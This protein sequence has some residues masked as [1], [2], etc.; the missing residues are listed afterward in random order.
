MNMLSSVAVFTLGLCVS[1]FLTP[2]IVGKL[3]A[4]AY[5][6]LGLS[7]NIISYTSLL[8]VI[9]NSMAGRFI[10]IQV[11][12]GDYNGANTYLSSIFFINIFFSVTILAGFI[13]F[14]FFMSD[15]INVPAN[16][17]ADVRI[18]F[19]LLGF[20]SCLGLV[21]GVI[22]VSTFIKNRL[23]LSN[24]RNLIGNLINA[25]LILLMF[26]LLPPRLWYYG[27]AGS[28]MLLYTVITNYVF[29]RRLTPELRISYHL[30]SFAHIRELA[31]AG[32]WN[33]ISRLSGLLNKGFNLLL[34]NLFISANA[35]GLLSIAQTIPMLILS[36]FSTLSGNFAPELTRLYAVGNK[37]ALKQ[38]FLRA[39][40]ISG[41]ICCIPC[42]VFF[43]YGDIFYGLWLP[44][45]NA[46]LMYYI[47][48][49]ASFGLVFALPQEPLWSIFTITNKVKR[50]SL[51]LLLNSTATFAVVMLAMFF[52]K[53]DTLRL[54]CL[55]GISSLIG[56]VRVLTFLPI[57]G[58]RCLGYNKWVFYPLIFKNVFNIVIVILLSFVI[59]S[60]IVE[61]SWVNLALG[62]FITSMVSVVF[63]SFTILK[64]TDRIYLWTHVKQKL[65]KR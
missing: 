22:S 63:S 53:D 50:S 38:E 56:S 27:I 5:G 64:K 10:T 37:E 33:A 26:G 13:L 23:D 16:L 48:C 49:L 7:N 40:R 54:Y 6:F 4:A 65:I 19:I 9:V 42:S 29:F 17:L 61:F 36:F 3:G 47:S 14:A 1:F 35:M 46:N 62:A 58:A 24:T 18:L 39:V 21:L 31:A 57:Y 32:V 15:V 44:N 55:A 34:A 51:N 60:K 45:Q 52:V 43:V 20:N 11:H 8:T 2:Y 41:F 30:F 25:S 59:K 28:I 12:K